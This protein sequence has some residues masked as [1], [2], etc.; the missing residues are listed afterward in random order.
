M[1]KSQYEYWKFTQLI[2]DVIDSQTGTFSL[3]GAEG[4]L[5]LIR[6]R[7]F[8]DEEIEKIGLAAKF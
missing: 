4:K 7:I 5:F 8:T 1:S 2:I 3:E 6:S